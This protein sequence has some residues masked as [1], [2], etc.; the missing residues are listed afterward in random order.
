MSA[1]DERDRHLGYREALLDR[2]ADQVDLEAVAHRF[3]IFQPRFPQGAVA[4]STVS[5]GYVAQ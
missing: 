1:L 3:D 4:V 2:P 5:S